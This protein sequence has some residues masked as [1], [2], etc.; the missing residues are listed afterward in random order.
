MAPSLP[1]CDL[2]VVGGGIVGACLA[3]EFARAG[4]SVVVADAGDEPGHA[5]PRAAG[6]AV[7][8]LRYLTEPEFFSWLERG[9]LQLA[10]DIARLEPEHGAFSVARPILRAVRGR[11]VAVLE[12]HRDDRDIGTWI[13]A[14]DAVALMPGLA[15][16]ADVQ[17]LVSPD[18]LVVNGA[19]YLAA[20]RACAIRAGVDWRQNTEVKALV[21]DEGGVEVVT[22]RGPIRADLVALCAGAWSGT[23]R[24]G[25]SVPVYPL[26]GQTIRLAAAEPSAHIFS[27]AH[28]M[29][30]DVDGL[31]VV[32]ATEEDA[33][34]EAHCTA[35]GVM[36]LLRFAVSTVPK[37]ADAT[38][39]GLSAGLRPATKTGQPFVGRMPGRARVYVA[40]GHAGHGLLSARYTATCL[41]QGLVRGDWDE[42]PELMCPQNG[43]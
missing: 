10:A 32:G 42:L 22:G 8:S 27:S 14:E 25:A 20:V 31:L 21:E 26:R 18:G 17:Y 34:F 39:V 33:G 30:P 36:R 23:S 43:H 28:Y 9:R 13:A 2:A 11:D 38:P 6:L 19:R 40:A 7:V 24:F 35:Q 15:P 41:V 4:A 1:P 37:L 16:G 3:E 12:R 5:T 29:A